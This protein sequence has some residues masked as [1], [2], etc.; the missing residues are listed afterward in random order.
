MKGRS[1]SP[2][3]GTLPNRI[4]SKSMQIFVFP[5]PYNT[6][7]TGGSVGF[8]LTSQYFK[9]RWLTILPTMSFRVSRCLSAGVVLY[10]K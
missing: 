4:E 5:S 6:G 9:I 8:I 7:T 1:H 3:F 2:G 10:L